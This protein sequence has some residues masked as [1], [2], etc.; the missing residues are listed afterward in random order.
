[1]VASIGDL[2]DF[3]I[4]P[5][6]NVSPYCYSILRIEPYLTCEHKCVYCFG[7]WYRVKATENLPVTKTLHT[8]TKLLKFLKKRNVKIMPFRLATLV[9]PFQPIEAEYSM[10]KHLMKLCL[11]YESPLIIN[12]KATL[13]L[14]ED[15]INVLEKLCDKSLAIVQISL[16]TI[17]DEI[18]RSIEPNAPPPTER[19]NAIERL[20]GNNI[21]VIVRLQPFIPGITD[22]ELEKIV[23]QIKYAG[24]RQ[25]IVESL[26]DEDE[27]LALYKKLAYEKQAYENLGA[28]EPYSPSIETSSKIMRVSV[29]WRK[30]AYT[31]ARELCDKF[32]LKFSTCKEGFYELH[33][34]ENC[35][36]MQFLNQSNYVLR[37]TLHEAWIYYKKKKV[38][39]SFSE[40]V[41]Y[42]TSNYVFGASLRRYPRPLRKK[43]LSHEKILLKILDEEAESLPRFIPSLSP[44]DKAN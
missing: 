2:E 12:T 21:P 6:I 3:V 15:Y 11:K 27:N 18:A 9:D 19:L 38:I 37:P 34:A 25:M 26:R 41:E 30:H 28:W 1:M 22:R 5:S 36:G 14:R 39:P 8:F 4:N 16:S 43:M 23:E 33:T 31:K 17:N 20:S 32:G 42:L 35:C 40:L 44:N 24:A 10:S 13:L 29:Q 7:R